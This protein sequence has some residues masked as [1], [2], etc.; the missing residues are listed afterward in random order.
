M[1]SAASSSYNS[2]QVSLNHRDKYDN[3]MIG[4]T[5]SKSMDNGSDVF[6]STNPY[7]PSR[8]RALSYFDLPHNFVASYTVQLPFNNYFGK[9]DIASRLT[10]GWAIS[11]ITSFVTGEVIDMTEYDDDNSLSGTY[12]APADRP[13][14]ANNGSKLFQ[15]GVSSK[16]PRNS[17][18]LP[19]FN[20][21]F[22]TT[23]PLGQIGNV[24]PRFF[25]G[26]GVNN[27]N[28]ALLKN[29]RIVGTTQLQIRA[30]AFNVF[31]HTQFSGADGE[32]GDSFK[33]GF[34][35]TTSAHDP[36]IMQVALK[37]L[38]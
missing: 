6:D 33:G 5:W 11:G 24:M 18:G 9:G 20:P 36:R 15:S 14:Y 16:N 12:N 37:L 3:F 1:K 23:E 13:S 32:I 25:H 29:T 21:N 31:N 30:E 28:L 34:G 19:Y 38:F 10:A 27:T 22:F 8:S 4:Y 17:S 2:L 7:D 26:P 35:Y